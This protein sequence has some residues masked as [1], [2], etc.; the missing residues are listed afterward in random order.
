VRFAV[1][2]PPFGDF[3]D[4]AAV[5]DLAV[6]AEA[7]GWD[8]FFLW[9]HVARAD[10]ALPVADA[11]IDL[12]AV[13]AATT[14]IR[15]G[16]MVTPLARRRPWVVARQTVTLDRLSA[17]RLI[18]G[19]GLGNDR[20]RELS[21]FGEETDPRARARLLDES[22]DVLTA[23]WAGEPTTYAGER[24]RVDGARFLPTPLQR[25]RIPI[26]VGGEWPNRAPLRR[27]AR[28]DGVFPVGVDRLTPDDVADLVAYVRAHRAPDAGPF[29]VVVSGRG[30]AHHDGSPAD[31]AALAAAGVTWWVESLQPDDAPADARALVAAG[32]PR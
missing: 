9:D 27:A 32:P 3:A 1:D 30:G 20:G 12:A 5:L 10:T 7:A 29:D 17:G 18:L 31:L 6:A 19:V 22:L 16:P 23:L 14:R 26:W 25:P 4:P 11:W 28:Y 8:A 21:T 13:A 15:I 24:L 2:L